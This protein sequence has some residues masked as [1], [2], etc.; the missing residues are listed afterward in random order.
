MAKA[1]T[2]TK[3]RSSLRRCYTRV[4]LFYCFFFGEALTLFAAAVVPFLLG[5]FFGVPPFVSTGREFSELSEISSLE[6]DR[7]SPSICKQTGEGDRY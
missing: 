1:P 6:L 2:H 3:G 7:T 5:C 4:L